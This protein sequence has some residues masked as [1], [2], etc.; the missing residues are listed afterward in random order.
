M[1]D[2]ALYKLSY[3]LYV[4][5]S[6][7]DG[8]DAGCVVNSLHQITASPVQVAVAINKNNF[9][10]SIVEKANHFHVAVLTQGVAMETI[11]DFGF[12]SSK[13]Y[14]KFSGKECQRDAFGIPYITEHVAASISCRVVQTLDVGTHILFVGEVEDAQQVCQEEVMTYAYYQQVKKGTTPKNASTYHAVKEKKV[15]WRCTICGYIYEG[16]PLPADF[17]CPICNAPASVFEKIS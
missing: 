12:H 11:G 14:D 16:D 8:K 17:V 10:T 13:D 5:S 7:F 1:D 6:T 15:G 4:I 3:G 9:T 2:K